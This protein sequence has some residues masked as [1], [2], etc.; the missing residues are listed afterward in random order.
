MHEEGLP[1]PLRG[2][3][4]PLATPLQSFDAI[5]LPGLE[6]LVEHVLAGEPHALFILGT[7]GEGP[8]LSYP[9]RRELIE[10]VCR[11]V[12]RRVPVLVGI[13]D[14]SYAESLR[15]AEHAA[16]S[17]ASAVVAAPPFYFPMT[18]SNLLRLIESLA[19]DATLPLYL[20]NQPGLTKI[21]FDPQTVAR[22]ADIP[23]VWGL[24]DSS[25]Q[26]G[27]LREVLSLVSERHPE[28]SVLAGPE[29][30]LAE[31]LLCGAHGGVPGGANIFPKLPAEL[32]RLFLERKL[33][34]MQQVQQRMIDIGSAIWSSDEA[35][36][37]YLRRLKCAL[38]V[39][40]LCS[41]M[42]AW[43]HQASPDEERR[44]IESHLSRHGILSRNQ[45]AARSS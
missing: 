17:G 44:Q 12:D 22:A 4:P 42:P 28:F 8:A 36:T 13:T 29:H 19:H 18:Q 26:I 6:T 11:Q 40:G 2:I 27:Y 33:E 38:S 25:G 41:G 37:G 35:D 1:R 23:K 32:Y 45:S 10:R 3:I 43:P 5:D 9:L 20:Y 15:L 14:P 30:L 16:D 39:L 21:R 7:T 24:K 31:A 34:E